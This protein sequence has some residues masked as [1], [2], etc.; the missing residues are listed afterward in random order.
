MAN[1]KKHKTAE[2]VKRVIARH[3]PDLHEEAIG[4][5][6]ADVATIV[7]KD[8]KASRIGRNRQGRNRLL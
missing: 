2:V 6:A 8:T 7:E 4:S 5:I 1:K 3:K